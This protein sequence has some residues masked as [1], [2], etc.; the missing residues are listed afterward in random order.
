MPFSASCDF[1]PARVVDGPGSMRATP[2]ADW[3]MAV[4]MIP[5]TAEEVQ[6]DEVDAGRRG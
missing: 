4:A 5:G 3:R 6:V 1:S 2:P